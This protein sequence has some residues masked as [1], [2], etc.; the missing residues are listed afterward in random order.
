MKDISEKPVRFHLFILPHQLDYLRRFAS[1][2]KSTTSQVL[3]DM[4]E[5]YVRGRF[6]RDTN[7]ELTREHNA[8]DGEADL[9]VDAKEV[10]GE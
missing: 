8:E 3:R 1:I 4:I 7:L 9:R 2:R 10:Y 5:D 6:F